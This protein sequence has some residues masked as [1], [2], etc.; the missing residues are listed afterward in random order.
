M[1]TRPNDPWVKHAF[2]RSDKV[3]MNAQILNA[4]VLTKRWPRAANPEL[5]PSNP[6]DFE[7]QASSNVLQIN[8]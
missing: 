7:P 2:K 4:E 3:E 1:S 8:V 5:G 6:G